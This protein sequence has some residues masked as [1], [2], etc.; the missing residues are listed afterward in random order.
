MMVA[1]L[2][3][4][5]ECVHSAAVP[6]DEVGMLAPVSLTVSVGHPGSSVWALAIEVEEH[7][8]LPRITSV[9]ARDALAAEE[10]GPSP[11]EAPSA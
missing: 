3:V 4:G 10:F 9:S 7:N 1:T 8:G 6:T 11:E 2:Y 5:E